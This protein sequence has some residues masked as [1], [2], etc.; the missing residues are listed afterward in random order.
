MPCSTSRTSP[1]ASRRRLEIPESGAEGVIV[2]Q[3]RSFRRLVALCE[4]RQVLTSSPTTGLRAGMTTPSP[5][6]SRCPPA[7]SRCEVRLR[8]RRRRARCRRYMGTLFVNDVQA[9]QGHIENT[10]G[11][12]LLAQTRAWTSV[13]ISPRR[14]RMSYR[15][16]QRS[17][18]VIHWVRIDIGDDDTQPP[19]G[20]GKAASTSPWRAIGRL[21]GRTN[22]DGLP[23]PTNAST[24]CEDMR[25]KE[26]L[27]GE[28]CVVRQD[29]QDFRSLFA[30]QASVKGERS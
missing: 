23:C 7:P 28:I 1:T 25:K 21:R 20:S 13:A 17:T 10:V 3:G 9:G 16:Q 5:P 15:A 19:A 30:F 6:R 2:A 11:L 14:L 26:M 18:G 24:C 22:A 12:Q 29:K 8:L 27:P 4:G